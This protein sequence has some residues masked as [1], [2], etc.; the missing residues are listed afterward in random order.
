MQGA[1]HVHHVANCSFHIA[2]IGVA[3]LCYIMA[4]SQTVVRPNHL[5]TFGLNQIL[6]FHAFQSLSHRL[7]TA[8]LGSAERRLFRKKRLPT[9]LLITDLPIKH[10]YVEYK[11]VLTFYKLAKQTK[12]VYKPTEYVSSKKKR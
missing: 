1:Y 9:Q 5:V 3:D 2:I 8:D 6:N 12:C 10:L 4:H 7:M 11:F